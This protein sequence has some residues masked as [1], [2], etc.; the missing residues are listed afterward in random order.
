M[1]E[2]RVFLRGEIDVA[3]A[4][5]VINQAR[6][7]AACEGGPVLVDCLDVTFID[8]AGLRALLRA[9]GELAGYGRDLRLV[10][11]SSAITRIL[12]ILDVTQLL[13]PIRSRESSDTERPVTTP[14]D[15]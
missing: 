2:C 5:E 4:D 9:Q 11:L 10:H 7:A 8:V 6:R 3:N 15:S 13:R 12:R 1:D 14:Q